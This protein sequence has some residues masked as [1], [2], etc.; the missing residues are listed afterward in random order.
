M[1][2][3]INTSV[4]EKFHLYAIFLVGSLIVGQVIPI[5]KL[6][7]YKIS[8]DVLVI[9]SILNIML[10][11]GF[12]LVYTVLTSRRLV[13]GFSSIGGLIGVI[14]G[15]LIFSI[16]LKQYRSQI[17][18]EFLITIPLIYSIS[19]IGCLMAGCCQGIYC[20]KFFYI[21]YIKENLTESVLPIQL[22]ESIVFMIIYLVAIKKELNT[23]RLM[24]LCSLGK[25]ILEFFRQSNID[26]ILNINQIIC[27]LILLITL[28][29][30]ME[31]KKKWTINKNVKN[32]E[33]LE[34]NLEKN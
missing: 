15:T 3:V 7:K 10:A 9:A 23:Y 11:L 18:K 17:I 22:L 13:L 24:Q 5:I 33:R 2:V 12:G 34:Y 19:K 30:E 20:N 25:L 28:I 8:N 31:M 32:S 26:K 1:E 14:I 21:T 4:N 27:I 6:H 29:I 16:I